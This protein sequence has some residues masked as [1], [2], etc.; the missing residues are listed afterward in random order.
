MFKPSYPQNDRQK[1]MSGMLPKNE[2][3]AL[4]K[5]QAGVVQWQNESFPSFRRGFDPLHP[6]HF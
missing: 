3:S 2:I 6:L 1:M 5:Y 4:K